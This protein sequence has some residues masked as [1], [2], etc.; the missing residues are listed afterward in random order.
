MREVLRALRPVKNR[1]RRN[2][3]LPGTAA[4][5]A[6]GAAAALALLAVTVFVPLEGRWILAGI[7]AAGCAVL[8][9]AG[10]A[11]RPVR[12]MEAAR[13]ADACGLQERAVTALETAGKTV[14]EGKGAAMLEAQR[15]DAC[16]HLRA[17]DVRKIRGKF[18][19]RLLICSAALALLCGATAL[20]PAPAD[21]I[22][23]KRR[24]VAEKVASMAE[25]IEKAEA[26]EEKGRSEKEK[27]ELRK[28]TDDLKRELDESRDAVDALVALDKA[29]KRLEALRQKTAGEA[30]ADALRSAGMNAA[31]DAL[32][33][34]DAQ[35]LAEALA[36][37]DAD[38]L[39][40]AAEELSEE[41]QEIAEQL[42]QAAENGGL[43]EAQ[44]QAVSAALQA[45]QS[46]GTSGEQAQAAASAAQANS[47]QGSALQQAL[48]GMKAALNG[49]NAGKNGNGA[50]GAGAGGQQGQNGGGA[51][52]GTTNQEEKGGGGGQQA[53]GKGNR[54]PE[55]KEGA[56]ETIYDPERVE[57][58][59]RD[60]TTEQQKLG[61][62]SVQI[63]AGPGKGR[64][65]GNVPY[66]EVIGEYAEAE[67]QAAESAHLTQQQKQWVDAYFRKLT[68]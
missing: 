27:A 55:Y 41:A 8:G 58:A 59:S 63:E 47:L 66:R 64:L 45:A 57:T 18:P 4:G 42:A 7:I 15:Q 60:V 53:G 48:S 49:Q 50:N 6:A 24:E 36:E 38:A 39:R 19:R 1:I 10:N 65:E 68:E 62:D 11:L 22:V 56:Y 12:D 54:P 52:T 40:K 26:E 14:A 29:E 61:E 9:A 23:A 67:T 5:L 32:A 3:L 20:I 37:L 33:G 46:G 30:L 2:R 43:S 31:A 17:L 44:A 25:Q 51:G 34:G 13:A 35:S 28:L 16:E 21:Q